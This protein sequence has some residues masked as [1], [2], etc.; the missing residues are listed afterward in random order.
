M[1]RV[2]IRR[3]LAYSVVPVLLLMVWT[4]GTAWFIERLN[5]VSR[6]PLALVFE[7]LPSSFTPDE[8]PSEHRVVCVGDSW[9]FGDGMPSDQAYPHQLEVLLRARGWPDATVLNLGRSGATP[10]ESSRTLARY[11]TT[12]ESVDTIVYLSGMNS[13]VFEEQIDDQR[14]ISPVWLARHWLDGLASYRL[15]TQLVARARLAN[16]ERLVDDVPLATGA[17]ESPATKQMSAEETEAVSTRA[18]GQNLAR[19]ADI[20]VA[21]RTRVLVLTYGIPH[22]LAST[23][24]ATRVVAT[25]HTIVESASELGVA[26]I[27]MMNVYEARGVG[28]DAMRSPPRDPEFPDMDPHP[29]GLGYAIYAETVADWIIG[30]VDG[31]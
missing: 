12:A 13:R 26:Y 5:L 1:P 16:D 10:Y 18:I 31:R 2:A 24:A 20:A 22:A 11:L 4:E 29:N 30:P 28:L 6:R 27:D 8:A 3:R 21:A 9:T 19:L 7:D 15:L 17:P 14:V 23:P 25:D